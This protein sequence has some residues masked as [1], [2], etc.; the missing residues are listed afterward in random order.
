MVL[1]LDPNRESAIQNLR[2]DTQRTN[3]KTSNEDIF[4]SVKQNLGSDTATSV[5]K[6]EIKSYDDVLKKD[7]KNLN[8]LINK[9]TALAE[10][11]KFKEAIDCYDKAL[12]IDSKNIMA[13]LN[14][15]GTF[16][17]MGDYEKATKYFDEVLKIE[18]KNKGAL[19]GKKLAKS[20]KDKS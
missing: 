12:K 7:P 13:L 11:D 18:P 5:I 1:E 20:F 3:K 6:N 9:G 10:I 4:E 19:K 8:A 16:G 15:A 2:L 14:K 17:R